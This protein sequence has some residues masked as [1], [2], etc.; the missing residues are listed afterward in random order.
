MS[1]S[2]RAVR[3]RV[4]FGSLLQRQTNFRNTEMEVPPDLEAAL[5]RIFKT[6][7]I[8]WGK[9]LE[10][11]TGIFINRIPAIRFIR[12]DMKLASGDTISFIPLVGGG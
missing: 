6:Y 3:I 2:A 9:D 8:L 5:A 7:G 4:R 11:C 10:E 1:N 12:E